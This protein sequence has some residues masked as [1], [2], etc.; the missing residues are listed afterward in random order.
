M[1]IG[2]NNPEKSTLK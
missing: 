2:G 1:G